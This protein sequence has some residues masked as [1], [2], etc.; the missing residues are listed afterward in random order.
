MN[1]NDKIL[2]NDG[3]VFEGTRE[4]FKDCFFSNADDVEIYDWAEDMGFTVEIEYVKS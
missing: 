1:P 3:G 2:V 4:Q